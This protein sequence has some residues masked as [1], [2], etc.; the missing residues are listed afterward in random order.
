MAVPTVL[1]SDWHMLNPSGREDVPKAVAPVQV[2][3]DTVRW[4]KAPAEMFFPRR[5]LLLSSS[6][7][8]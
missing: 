4:K 3:F 7:S 8:A 1:L 5:K 2:P 6:I